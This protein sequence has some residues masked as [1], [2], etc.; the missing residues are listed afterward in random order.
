MSNLINKKDL[1]T[2][3]GSSR[4]SE[5]CKRPQKRNL[6]GIEGNKQKKCR[7]ILIDLTTN[8]ESNDNQE[9]KTNNELEP[10]NPMVFHKRFSHIMVREKET[11]IWPS[12]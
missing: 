8:E 3:K 6:N 7:P 4:Y 5:D 10:L 1:R 12:L 11:I 9:A 2:Q